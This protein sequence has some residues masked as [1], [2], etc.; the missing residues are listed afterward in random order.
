MDG[1]GEFRPL[2]GGD[3]KNVHRVSLQIKGVGRKKFELWH[4]G[5]GKNLYLRGR[6]TEKMLAPAQEKFTNP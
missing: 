5:A 4:V 1:G 6:G 2:Y 3:Q